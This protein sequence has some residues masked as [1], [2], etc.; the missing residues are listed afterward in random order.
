MVDYPSLRLA[1]AAARRDILA[2]RAA[3]TDL[4]SPAVALSDHVAAWTR[5][6]SC[7]AAYVPVGS[8][9]GSVALLDALTGRGCRVLLPIVSADVLDWAAYDGVLAPGPWGLRQP[10]GPRL[11]VAALATAD[12]VLVPALAADR[13]GTRLGR[14]AGFYDRSLRRVRPGTPLAALL[15]DGE[16]VEQLLPAEPHD[17]PVTAAITPSDGVVEL[18]R[19]G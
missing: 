17:V 8:E 9:P 2:R 14:G 4:A 19:S 15:H 12:A 10:A 3:L 11:G 16:L 5:A 7:V 1:K 6:G 18:T 13:R